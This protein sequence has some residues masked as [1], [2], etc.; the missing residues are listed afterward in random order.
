VGL[1]LDW[2]LY[3]G[4]A[5][6]AQRHQ[7][8]GQRLE[9]QMRLL[10]MRDTISDEI[11]NADETIRV[12]KKALEAASVSVGLSKETLVLVEAQHDA[13][14][15]T[16]LDLLQAQDALVSAEVALAQARFDLATAQLTLDRALGQW[17]PKGD[18]QGGRR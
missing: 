16:Q 1:Q 9:T 14:T 17:P 3:D 6:D 18:S 10:R 15:A 5:R 11:A 12:K 7:L 4:G 8:D 2:V 13:G